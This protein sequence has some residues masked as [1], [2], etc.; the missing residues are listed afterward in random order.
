MTTNAPGSEKETR[1]GVG[2]EIGIATTTEDIEEPKTEQAQTTEDGKD[3]PAGD[4]PIIKPDNW[5]NT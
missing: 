5:N 2:V 3:R 1:S 4:G